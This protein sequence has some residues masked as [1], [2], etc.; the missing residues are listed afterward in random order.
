MRYP[1][2]SKQPNM[3][4]TMV[5][6]SESLVLQRNFDTT[7]TSVMVDKNYASLV[8]FLIPGLTNTPSLTFLALI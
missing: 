2:A 3:F 7:S 6:L 4:S 1:N 5:L 8:S